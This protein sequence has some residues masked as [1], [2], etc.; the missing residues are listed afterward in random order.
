M[1][2][3]QIAPLG[4][5]VPPKKYG[6][7]ERVIYALTEGLVKRGHDVTLFASGDSKTSARHIA[8]YPKALR[9]AHSKNP[10]GLEYV[11]M[12]NIGVAYNHQEEFDIIHDHNVYLSLPTAL[13]AT[14]PVIM[15]LHGAF[16]YE[17]IRY[18]EGL[19]NNKNPYFVSISKAQRVPL[20][21]LNYIANIHHGLS[22]KNY[23]F[24]RTH[25]G[26]LLYVGRIAEEKG[27]H[28]AIDVA[29][30]T[31]FPLIIA[32][33][34]DSN[35]LTYFKEKIEPRLSKQ[36]Q[37]I[38]EVDEDTRNKLMSKAMCFLHPVLWREPFGLTLIEA[39]SCGCPVIA[40]RRGSIPEIIENGKTGFIVEDEIEMAMRVADIETID[41][42][43]CRSYALENFNTDR[44]V[45]SYEATYEKAIKLFDKMKHAKD[46]E[47]KN[48]VDL[49]DLLVPQKKATFTTQ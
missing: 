10:Y 39:M 24:S 43:Y 2:I 48:A 12:L 8:V 33:K 15:T 13:H 40:F 5:R 41:R 4:E 31:N 25:E 14:I 44:M 38:G 46:N 1:R 37:W 47:V 28:L 34:V 29:E 27:V 42:S 17:N 3:A 35:D 18:F 7:T 36:I 16:N 30:Q 9:D 22:M 11:S 20:P 6:G 32:A 26:Y 45:D 21:T 19:Q 49:E 23:P